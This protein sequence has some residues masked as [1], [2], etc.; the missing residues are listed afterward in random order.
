[1]VEPFPLGQ[2]KCI[3]KQLLEAVDHMHSNL[4]LHR[5]IKLPNLLLNSKGEVKLG[6]FGLA[7]ECSRPVED[8]TKQVVTL[9]Y[10]APEILLGTLVYGPGVD[11]WSI[12]CVL[13]ELLL[14]KPLFGG[15]DE[16][17]QMSIICNH[18]GTPTEDSWPG[19]TAL[20]AF[21]DMKD[22]LPTNTTN[23]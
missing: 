14:H 23:N 16:T 1:M 18:L 13:G 8:V 12:G 7:R 4:L 22:V 21:N 3:V 11:V 9:W 20:P 15:R 19:V 17:H 2:V 6:D 5:D 10:R